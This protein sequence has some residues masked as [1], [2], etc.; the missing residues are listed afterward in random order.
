MEH[1]SWPLVSTTNKFAL[2][3]G[4][5]AAKNDLEVEVANEFKTGSKTFGGNGDLST[6]VH[7]PH[8]LESSSYAWKCRAVFFS[9]SLS[10]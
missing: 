4:N 7:S 3:P 10:L 6:V 9:S 5:L 8:S 1:G 2:I